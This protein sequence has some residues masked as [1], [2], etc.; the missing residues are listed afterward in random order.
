[1]FITSLSKRFF[2][3]TRKKYH[4]K[5]G[6]HSTR[7]M[8]SQLNKMAKTLQ[9]KNH[10]A[11]GGGATEHACM[12]VLRNVDLV[13]FDNCSLFLPKGDSLYENFC[14]KTKKDQP[15]KENS[16]NR[17]IF[18]VLSFLSTKPNST[19][20]FID[21]GS[22]IGDLSV[23]YASYCKEKKIQLIAHAYDPSFAGCLIPYNIL[24]NGVQNCVTHFPLAISI[25]SEKYIFKQT[26]GAS[27][28]AHLASN[29]DKDDAIY[30]P[31]DAV[32]LASCINRMS[33]VDHLIVKLDIEKGL[34]QKIFISNADLCKNHIL[35]SEFS[36][37]KNKDP[38]KH[39]L[40]KIL[41][42]HSIF[43][44]GYLPNPFCFEEVH[45]SNINEFIEN[46]D[47]RPYRYT[48]IIAF[49][50]NLKNLD[51]LIKRL[52]G[53]ETDIVESDRYIIN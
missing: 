14:H 35:M 11:E 41:Q 53:L 43:D 40:K 5:Y 15:L 31:V 13:P 48:D 46:V 8:Q 44:L 27:D 28:A 50:K 1:M 20:G 47:N 30:Y 36:L 23:R 42:T 26:K 21:G 12:N 6:K 24:L 3:E 19:I 2:K 4:L 39:F 38:N 37:L 16:I 7:A 25:K 45:E 18:E 52:Q 9:Q 34:E 51:Q 17:S 10:N 29:M 32:N 49:P 33:Q 22:W